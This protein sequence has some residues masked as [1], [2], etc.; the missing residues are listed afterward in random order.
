MILDV[1]TGSGRQC[2]QYAANGGN[3]YGVDVAM[4][5]LRVARYKASLRRLR[6]E[7]V[8]SDG[9]ALPF[10]D[11]GFDLVACCGSVLNYCED[12]RLA[13]HEFS[14]LLKRGGT[15]VVSFDSSVSLNLRWNRLAT[16]IRARIIS[17]SS[18]SPQGP[19]PMSRNA[20]VFYPMVTKNSGTWLVPETF[21][22]PSD[23]ISTLRREGFMLVSVTGIHILSGLMPYTALSNPN[24]GNMVRTVGKSLSR[25]DTFLKHTPIIK[26]LAD[27]IALIATKS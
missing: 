20:T 23:L 3:V 15:L 2:I 4:K 10:R 6:V 9:C 12:F 13:V 11:E 26:G 22:A 24:A 25:L 5:F 17:E 18:S 21:I 14:R 7:F 27:H 1:G 16:R 19:V 8:A